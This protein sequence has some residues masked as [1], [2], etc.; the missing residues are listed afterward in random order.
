[1]TIFKV[2]DKIAA[3]WNSEST[4]NEKCIGIITSII[5]D[6][7]EMEIHSDG[8]Q[9]AW[10]KP[11]DKTTW[12]RKQCRKIVGKHRRRIWVFIHN[13]TGDTYPGIYGS[14]DEEAKDYNHKAMFDYTLTEFVQV[15]KK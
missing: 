6:T 8:A 2:G 12:H 5:G 10:F 3:Y 14:P 13:K 11:G 4:D 9:E 1:M 15:K 7:I